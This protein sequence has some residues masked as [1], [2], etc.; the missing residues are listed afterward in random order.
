MPLAVASATAPS[1]VDIVDGAPVYQSTHGVGVGNDTNA[2]ISY[3]VQCQLVDSM[4]RSAS[5]DHDCVVPANTQSSAVGP[6]FLQNPATDPSGTSIAFTASTVVSGGLSDS[7][8][9]AGG[10]T[11]P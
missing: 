5:S 3:H 4:G 11:V 9:V 6:F 1:Q 2:D 10:F 8:S 7:A